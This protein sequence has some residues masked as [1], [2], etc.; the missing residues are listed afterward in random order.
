MKLYTSLFL[1]LLTC[2]VSPQLILAQ[3]DARGLCEVVLLSGERFEGMLENMSERKG[4]ID[5]IK[6]RDK[7]GNKHVFASSEISQL[8]VKAMNE[9]TE[10]FEEVT[11][12][13]PAIQPHNVKYEGLFKLLKSTESG[14]IKVY[15]YE[16]GFKPYPKKFL[17]LVE[18]G[19]DVGMWVVNEKRATRFFKSTFDYD[20]YCF[21]KGYSKR[22]DLTKKSLRFKEM[23]TYLDQFDT[24]A[25]G[26]DQ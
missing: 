18:D 4:A 6:I 16:H 5:K 3:S 21:F 10:K 24:D 13:H 8:K 12:E 25:M 9:L 1:I 15:S 22:A 2:L 23:I 19:I 11:Y 26:I 7:K 17:H 20:F 14:L